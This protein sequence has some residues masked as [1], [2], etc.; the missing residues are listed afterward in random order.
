MRSYFDYIRS[1]WRPGTAG[2]GGLQAGNIADWGQFVS[3]IGVLDQQL[4]GGVMES[5]IGQTYSVETTAP[6]NSTTGDSLMGWYR[7]MID[8]CRAPKLA[9]FG[10]DNWVSGDFQGMRYGLATTLMDD[11]YYY[12][13][14]M[15]S[16]DPSKLLW[17]DEFSFD[18]GYPIQPRQEA[19]WSQG[20]WRRD[21]DNG[22]VLINPKG[23]GP[24]TVNLGGTFR[25]L[26]GSPD[27]DPVT[28]NGATVTSVTLT[29]RDGIILS[30]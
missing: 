14:G 13:S 20:V 3:T 18:L 24:R 27:Q 2:A 7:K 26:L 5:M 23:N 30:R 19:Q 6:F 9:I 29:D 17:F 12:I 10:H 11:A 15:T 28:N 22:I 1:I 25:K 16:Y 8:A 21:F 4:D